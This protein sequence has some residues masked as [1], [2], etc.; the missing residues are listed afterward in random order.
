MKVWIGWLEGKKTYI[1][2]G[3]VCLVVLVLVYLGRLTPTTAMAIAL[4]ALGGFAA[5]FRAAL[6][7]H[8]EDLLDLLQAVAATGVAVAAHNSGA[9][10]KAGAAAV[11]DGARVEQEIEQGVKS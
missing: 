7:A 1:L 3:A 10:L 9:A 6:A 4:L 11:E 8:Q 2:A 5:T